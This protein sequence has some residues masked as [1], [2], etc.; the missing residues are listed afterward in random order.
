M[1]D[2][3]RPRARARRGGVA[4][5]RVRRSRRRVP[6]RGGAAGAPPRRG[7]G[8]G[9]GAYVV[10]TYV[11]FA[12]LASAL[13]GTG[14][15]AGPVARAVGRGGV[16]LAGLTAAAAVVAGMLPGAAASVAAEVAFVLTIP[17]MST[18]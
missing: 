7:A 10:L 17:F 15:V 2:R 8:P 3:P 5:A 1:A 9:S 12:G 14:L 6:R 13:G 18:L 11:G 4:D 16:G